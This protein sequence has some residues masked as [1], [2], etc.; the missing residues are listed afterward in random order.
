MPLIQPGATVIVHVG[1][2]VAVILIDL[3]A[4]IALKSTARLTTKNYVFF[5]GNSHPHPGV[6]LTLGVAAAT[7]GSQSRGGIEQ[8][9][10]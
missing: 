1:E 8:R 5:A 2:A 4:D 7:V 10:N 3:L 9:N 6:I